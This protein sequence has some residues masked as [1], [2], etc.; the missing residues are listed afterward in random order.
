ML[1]SNIKGPKQLF[2]FEG[3]PKPSDLEGLEHIQYS[4]TKELKPLLA[5]WLIDNVNE[6][7]KA[8]LKA[9]YNI[10]C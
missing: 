2:L 1:V 9:K 6:S 7:N 4:S 3:S 8:A 5:K 10:V